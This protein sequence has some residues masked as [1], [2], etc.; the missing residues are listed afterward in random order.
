MSDHIIALGS[1]VD[2][3][4]MHNPEL[5]GTGTVTRAYVQTAGDAWQHVFTVRLD[6]GRTV[7]APSRFVTLL[8][9]CDWHGCPE[10]ARFNVRR[11][12]PRGHTFT[13]LLWTRCTEHMP[14]PADGL[15][16]SEVNG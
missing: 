5:G 9:T 15:H 13:S 3:Y 8:P 6:S 12:I 7:D 1:R 2:V 4:A 16:V 14:E 10:P 11:D